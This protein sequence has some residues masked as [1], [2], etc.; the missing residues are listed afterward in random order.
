MTQFGLILKILKRPYEV[1]LIYA[2]VPKAKKKRLSQTEG[3]VCNAS[4]YP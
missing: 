2:L 1:I 4:V 3:L